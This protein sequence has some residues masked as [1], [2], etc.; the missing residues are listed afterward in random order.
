MESDEDR[1]RQS[2]ESGDKSMSKMD[3][4]ARN[5]DLLRL[6]TDQQMQDLNL[7]DVID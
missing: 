7:D 3:S 6:P 1:E 2:E 4:A 5:S